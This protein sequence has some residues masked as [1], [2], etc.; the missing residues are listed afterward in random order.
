[1]LLVIC[2]GTS[3]EKYVLP[4]L[5][6]APDTLRFSASGGTQSFS[7]TTNVICTID[8]DHGVKWI[9]A[10]PD[11]LE[12][13]TTVRITVEANPDAAAREAALPLKTE[14]FLKYLTVIQE[15]GSPQDSATALSSSPH[16]GL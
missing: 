12:E 6:F 16:P 2:Q 10:D 11:F 13:S 9:T 14:S 7:V 4:E 8:K 1:M 3:C 5:S 15:A